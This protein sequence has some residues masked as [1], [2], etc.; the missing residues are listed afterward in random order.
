ML[1]FIAQVD[2]LMSRKGIIV[3]LSAT[4]DLGC[5]VFFGVVFAANGKEENL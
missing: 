2:R 5:G 1:I 3:C 4:R